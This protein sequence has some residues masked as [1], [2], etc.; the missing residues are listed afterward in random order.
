MG[1]VVGALACRTGYCWALF[2]PDAGHQLA[3]GSVGAPQGQEIR[4]LI[5]AAAYYTPATCYK[6]R[7]PKGDM[8]C[9][10][11]VVRVCPSLLRM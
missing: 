9:S 3:R 10:V 11:R 7:L 6:L 2:D 4:Y 8:L 1:A 5:A